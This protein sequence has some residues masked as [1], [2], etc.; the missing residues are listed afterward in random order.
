MLEVSRLCKK[1][2]KKTVLNNISFNI[3]KG[4]I[5]AIVGV[6]GAG[7][8]TLFNIMSG[9][10]KADA[11]RCRFDGIEPHEI[12]GKSLIYLPDDSYL[13][14]SFTPRQMLM[15]INQICELCL[16]DYDIENTI[17]RFNLT[18]FCDQKI[19]TLSSGMTKRTAIACTFMQNAEYI[20]LDEPTNNID[21][22][23]VIQ[24][25]NEMNR[26]K[27]NGSII[28]I[29]SHV[30]DFVGSI[31]DEVIFIKGGHIAKTV[32]TQNND[33]EKQYIELFDLSV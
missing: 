8:T 32:L 1:Y 14:P 17:S 33:L 25:K 13:I 31:A 15:Y 5:T 29:S 21:T 11:G 4:S 20:I 3:E 18:E 22:Q 28:L 23:T 30:L 27:S 9:L 7:K 6:N 24:L 12:I 16:Q 26:L 19:N 2:G 10:I